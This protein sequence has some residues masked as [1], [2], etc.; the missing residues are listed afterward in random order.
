MRFI[1]ALVCALLCGGCY[2]SSRPEGQ[3]WGW[4]PPPAAKGHDP[5]GDLLERFNPILRSKYYRNDFIDEMEDAKHWWAR[6]KA[7][8]GKAKLFKT[9]AGAACIAAARDEHARRAISMA[10]G[11][12]RP[13]FVIAFPSTY[14]HIV[15][16]PPMPAYLVSVQSPRA[17]P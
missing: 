9:P 17:T 7:R 10:L 3:R 8:E 4:Q 13:T 11:E 15:S 5:A 14:A 2:D 1:L 16:G 12:P 6:I